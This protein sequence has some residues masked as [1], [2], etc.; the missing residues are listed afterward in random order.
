MAQRPLERDKLA[1][2]LEIGDGAARTGID[3]RD[4]AIIDCTRKALV[5]VYKNGCLRI[6]SV[7]DSVKKSPQSSPPNP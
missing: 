1:K 4:A 6:K 7:S 2:E 5:L 3:Q